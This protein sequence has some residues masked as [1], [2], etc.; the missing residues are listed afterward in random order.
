MSKA[1]TL[2]LDGLIRPVQSHDS[3]VGELFV[4]EPDIS[5]PVRIGWRS[6]I[7]VRVKLNILLY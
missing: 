1:S 6:E 7:Y 5:N 3:A 2:Q 4:V